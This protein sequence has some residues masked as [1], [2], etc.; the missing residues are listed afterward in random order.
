MTCPHQPSPLG[1]G[2]SLLLPSSAL[3]QP[4]L[5]RKKGTEGRGTVGEP[6][7]GTREGLCLR[8]PS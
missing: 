5:C 6:A 2:K 7:W 1:P 4:A 3:S 8:L